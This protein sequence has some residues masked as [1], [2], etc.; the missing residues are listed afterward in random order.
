[1][2]LTMDLQEYINSRV[3]EV[4]EITLP[5]RRKLGIY[6]DNEKLQGEFDIEYHASTAVNLVKLFNLFDASEI[7]IKEL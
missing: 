3:G 2:P 6:P 7:I 4:I 1:M 5:D